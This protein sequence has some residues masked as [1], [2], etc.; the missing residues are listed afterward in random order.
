MTGI[1]NFFIDNRVMLI[2]LAFAAA[3]EAVLRLAFGI[4]A[5][6]IELATVAVGIIS[7]DLGRRQK[8]SNFFFNIIFS[9]LTIYWFSQ[10][11]L[12]GQ[13]A[14][15]SVMAVIFIVGIY[16]W[17]HPDKN[18]KL[19]RPTHLH[20]AARII[21]YGGILILAAVLC[22]QFGAVKA[23]DYT[24]MTMVIIGAMLLTRK[25][26]DVWILYLIADTISIFLFIST[27]GF[28][29]LA[30]LLC[31]IYNEAK[32]AREWNMEIAARKKSNVRN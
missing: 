22:F 9:A 4:S 6:P 31:A 15:R 27:G 14:M 11:G 32:A 8:V 12:Y 3:F 20:P 10:I 23:M 17:L 21:I 7:L 13:V 29:Y 1:K 5:P 25:K 16:F 30:F 28:A 19:I 2:M 26:I 18:K 24:V